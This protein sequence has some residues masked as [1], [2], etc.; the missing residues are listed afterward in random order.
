V[1]HLQCLTGQ[2]QANTQIVYSGH[3]AS[4]DEV[5]GFG[6]REKGK[7]GEVRD[8]GHLGRADRSGARLKVVSVS[9]GC[10]GHPGSCSQELQSRMISEP[11]LGS[12]LV[13]EGALKKTG[14]LLR[15]AISLHPRFISLPNDGCVTPKAR[16]PIL[17]PSVCPSER[18]PLDSDSVWPMNS[19]KGHARRWEQISQY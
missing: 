2:P 17:P 16:G 18:A 5:Y 15:L 9:G 6:S 11:Q 12:P 8:R 10:A 1:P 4:N 7:G 14:D 13:V 3:C 19:H